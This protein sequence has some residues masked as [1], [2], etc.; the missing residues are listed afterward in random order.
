ME[1]I[2][3]ASRSQWNDRKVREPEAPK[4]VLKAM[5]DRDRASAIIDKWHDRN[6]NHDNSKRNELSKQRDIAK[7]AVLFAKTAA[8]ALLA[9]DRFEKWCNDNLE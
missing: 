8:A 1:R 6:R 3:K 5:R 2:N 9:T 4:R 7:Q